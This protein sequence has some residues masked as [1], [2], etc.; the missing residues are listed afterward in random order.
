MNKITTV[1][2]DIDDTLLD[3]NK[4]AKHSMF[5][6]FRE[7]SIA[8][9]E[10][11]FSVFTEENNLLWKRV[12]KRE[13]AL[14]EL[15]KIRF[16]IILKR[17]GIEADGNKIEKAFLKNLN[18]S[19]EPVD[20]AKEILE[21]LSSRYNVYAASNAPY[22]QQIDRLKIAD[23][24]QYF[25]GVFVS[26]EIGFSKPSKEFFNYCL[27]NSGNPNPCEV[28]MIGDSLSSD[29][30]GAAEMGIKTCWFNR[31]N[32]KN[33]QSIKSDYIVYSLGEIKNIL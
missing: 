32:G 20:G 19:A 16:D 31:K 2:I 18:K 27:E 24:M 3:F 6:S 4:C 14:D 11:Y 33:P 15:Y 17:L 21:F 25:S 7:F 10:E 12:E 9:K 5:L 30:S 13:L 28:L 22:R 23:M 26:E 1:F 8:P 29:I